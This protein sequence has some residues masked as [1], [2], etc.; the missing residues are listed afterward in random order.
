MKRTLFTICLLLAAMVVISC[1]SSGSGGLDSAGGA[2]ANRTPSQ[3]ASGSGSSG[4]RAVNSGVPQF[5]KDALKK[6]PQDAVI[7]IGTARMANISQSRTTA[8]TRARAEI[9]RTMESLVQD[10]VRDY[11]AGSEV[12]HSA[13]MAF[14]ENITVSL[15]RSRLVGSAIVEEDM[16]GNGQYWIVM[17]MGKTQAV[18][19][20]NQAAAAAKLAVPAAASFSAEERMNA[21]FD[22]YYSQELGYSD[23]N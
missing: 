11:F 12:D 10:M 15:S 6:A 21:A 16:D 20:I 23:R 9:S 2:A 18:N 7:G 3:T 17:M 5:V 1:A 13:V 19:E 14:T 22:K 8:Q 4:G